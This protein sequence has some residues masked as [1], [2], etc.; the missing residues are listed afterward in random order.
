MQRNMLTKISDR[1]EILRKSCIGCKPSYL[2]A[3][4]FA[5]RSLKKVSIPEIVKGVTIVSEDDISTTHIAKVFAENIDATL[6]FGEV[7]KVRDKETG[8]TFYFKTLSKITFQ[9]D[10][11][12]NSDFWLEAVYVPLNGNSGED[13]VGEKTLDDIRTETIRTIKD[14]YILFKQKPECILRAARYSASLG[15]KID[16]NTLLAMCYRRQCIS[17]AVHKGVIRDELNHILNSDHPEYGIDALRSSGVL[18]RVIPELTDLF[19]DGDTYRRQKNN[20]IHSLVVLGNVAKKT[21]DP[22]VRLAALLHDIGKAKVRKWSEQKGW[23][24]YNHDVAGVTMSQQIMKRLG[25]G[26]SKV[27][28]LIGLHMRPSLMCLEENLTDSAIRRLITDSKGYIEDLMT[29]V[30]SDITTTNTKK[31]YKL[32]K[33]FK[34]LKRKIKELIE[35]DRVRNYKPSVQGKEIMEYYGIKPC[36]LI[37]EIKNEMKDLIMEGTLEDNKEAIYKWLD[38]ERGRFLG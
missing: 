19:D 34:V 1:I 16:Q 4:E 8:I 22:N 30:S 18:E 36:N 21:K 14:P 32:T 5:V 3:G 31:R 13:V 23:T 37:G 7:L 6:E 25:I 33:G 38:H 11:V 17:L 9:E 20:Y 10:V 15:F 26:N 28:L 27:S 12:A 35:K 24:F 2:A 29:L